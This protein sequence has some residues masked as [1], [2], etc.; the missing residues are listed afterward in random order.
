ML[1]ALRAVVAAADDVAGTIDQV[2]CGGCR[3]AVAF[4]LC[5]DF[6]GGDVMRP[7]DQVRLKGV[8]NSCSPGFLL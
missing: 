5:V 6:R 7:V 4:V 3:V 2:G 8:P 1:A